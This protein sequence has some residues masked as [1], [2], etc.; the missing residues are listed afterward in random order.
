MLELQALD[1]VLDDPELTAEKFRRWKKQNQELYSEWLG[2]W[3]VVQAEGSS[4]ALTPD[5][6]EQ[7]PQ[8]LP[9]DPEE[10][11]H[12]CPLTSENNLQ[13]PDL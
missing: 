4:Q 7:S 2:V 11:S 3:G 13:P 10:P 5:S 1:E 12:L 8:P 9:S 6:R